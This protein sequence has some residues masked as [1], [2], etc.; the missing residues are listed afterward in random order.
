MQKPTDIVLDVFPRVEKKIKATAES[1]SQAVSSSFST[2]NEYS[3]EFLKNK[4]ADCKKRLTDKILETNFI[5][6]LFPEKNFSDDQLQLIKYNFRQISSQLVIPFARPVEQLRKLALPVLAFSGTVIGMVF[7]GFLFRIS[8]GNDYR[9]FGIIVGGAV[10]AFLLTMISISLSKREYLIRI[11]QGL[12]GVAIAT[13]VITLFTGSVNPFGILWRKLTGRFGSGMIGK[14]KRIGS[15]VLGILILQVA[16]PEEKLPKKQLCENSYS[17]IKSWLEQSV[18]SL[19]IIIAESADFFKEED[20]GKPEKTDFQL[21]KTLAKL[22]GSGDAREAELTCEEIVPAFKN[23]GY[24]V[25]SKEMEAQLVF[26]EILKKE[27]DIEGYI[28][29]GDGYKIFELPLYQNDELIIRGKLT[30][31]R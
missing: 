4:A 26:S 16:V 6:E 27:F 12:F 5:A 18:K 3:R 29:E 23:A 22:A 1:E 10:G 9:Q 14:L 17:A 30:K 2:I 21:L 8:L 11:L 15:F 13:E 20:K 25:K 31:K 24:E 28:N 19:I 7:S